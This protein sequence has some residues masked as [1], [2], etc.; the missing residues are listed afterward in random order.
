MLRGTPLVEPLFL[1][2][3]KTATQPLQTSIAEPTNLDQ[4]RLRRWEAG[5]AS[6]Y[7]KALPRRVGVVNTLDSFGRYLMCC[8]APAH[9]LHW[10]RL[11][12]DT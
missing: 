1:M 12:D 3:P 10:P 9:C 6:I 4:T 8:R 5:N 7:D 2:Y 11:R